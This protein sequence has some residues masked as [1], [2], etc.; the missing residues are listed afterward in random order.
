MRV[1]NPEKFISEQ[2][3]F[4]REIVLEGPVTL[5]KEKVRICV[6]SLI[7]LPLFPH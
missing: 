7:F 4:T 2:L 5:K 1:S 6:L 3:N